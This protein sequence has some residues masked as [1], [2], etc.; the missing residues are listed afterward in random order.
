MRGCRISGSSRSGQRH[1]DLVAEIRIG[2]P[3]DGALGDRLDDGARVR[4]R[5]LLAALVLVLAADAA[6]V[7]QV[8][9]E[10]AAVH[11]LQEAIS[12]LLVTEREER[13]GAGDAQELACLLRAAC[14]RPARLAEHE[15]QRCLLAVEPRHARG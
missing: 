6:G 9:L 13:I 7:E 3:L 10:V 2:L 1:G 5:H 8:D 4:N 14:R 12:L 11:E 15:I